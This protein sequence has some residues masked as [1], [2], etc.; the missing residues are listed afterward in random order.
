MGGAPGAPRGRP[1]RPRRGKELTERR[2]DRRPRNG[3]RD[4][5]AAAQQHK[6]RVDLDELEAAPVAPRLGVAEGSHDALEHAAAGGKVAE[7]LVGEGGAHAEKVEGVQGG[8][9]AEA[10]LVA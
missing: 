5:R 7:L 6:A 1:P 8:G 3:E 2:L 9:A 10:R 4:P